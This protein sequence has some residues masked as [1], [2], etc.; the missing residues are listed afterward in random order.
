MPHL[1]KM[2]FEFFNNLL[3]GNGGEG[4]NLNV[5]REVFDSDEKSLTL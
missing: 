2:C 3:A 4:S 5:S 1:T